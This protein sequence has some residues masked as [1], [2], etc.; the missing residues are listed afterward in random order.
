MKKFRLAEAVVNNF[1]VNWV[2]ILA[3]ACCLC[4]CASAPPMIPIS[5]ADAREALEII[6]STGKRYPAE[7]TRADAEEKTFL[8][9]N[10]LIAHANRK[11]VEYGEL[12]A[13]RCRAPWEYSVSQDSDF[14][15][16][17]YGKK[18]IAV[19]TG[20]LSLVKSDDELAFILAHELGHHIANHLSEQK[21]R[22]YVGELVGG[23][24]SAGVTV[25]VAGA[26]GLE[27][28]PEFED[29]DYL[30]DLVS[31]SFETGAIA[32][33]EVAVMR[34]SR[35][36]EAEADRIAADIISSAGFNLDRAIE[37]YAYLGGVDGNIA[38]FSSFGDSHPT[39]LERLAQ[40]RIFSKWGADSHSFANLRASAEDNNS[41]AQIALGRK[42]VTKG[43][44]EEA[45]YWFNRAAALKDPE[46][47]LILGLLAFDGR[48]VQKDKNMAARWFY[49]AATQGD[50]N[51]QN[52][53]GSQYASGEGVDQDYE[54]SL[55]WYLQSGEQGNLFA[56]RVLGHIFL[57]GRGTD[58]N[59]AEA[60]RW[61]RLAAEKGDSEA[62]FTLSN[63]LRNRLVDEKNRAEAFRWA[64]AAAE[65]GMVAAQFNVAKMYKFGLG[66]RQ[67]FGEAV[68]WATKA[69]N[70]GYDRAQFLL[71]AAYDNGLGVTVDREKAIKLYRLAAEQGHASAQQNLGVLS[72]SGAE[73]NQE[74]ADGLA[75]AS[76]AADKGDPEAQ[77]NL[78]LAYERAQRFALARRWYDSA[79][80][81]G[82]QPALDAR[83]MLYLVEFGFGSK[84]NV[85]VIS[86][87]RLAADSGDANAQYALGLGHHHSVLVKQSDEKAAEWYKL[88]AAQDHTNAQF[89]LAV[90]FDEG[91]L[92]EKDSSKAVYWYRRAAELGHW[93]AQS[94]LG[95][96]LEYGDG[97]E[98]DKIAAY[99]WYLSAA[100]QGDP[101]TQFYVG[102]EYLHGNYLEKD[103]DEGLF[104][105][106]LAAENG[107]SS[108]ATTLGWRYF[109]KDTA[110]FNLNYKEAF[111][112]NKAGA[113]GG[114][115]NAHSNLALHYFTG[116]GVEQ[117]FRRMVEH[118]ILSAEFFT[119]EFRWV[120]EGPDEWLDYKDLA[121]K[122]FM[123]ARGLWWQAVTTGDKKY[124]RRLKALI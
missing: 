122:K 90:L 75:W 30:T 74:T 22:S 86:D 52:M 13:D 82:F 49:L 113:E 80:K 62:Q 83:R 38:T 120:T 35:Q 89:S 101:D 55:S 81:S 119:D 2:L 114:H 28:N 84:S 51:A 112:W 42:S 61:L 108:A 40:L 121:P 24:L 116:Y 1:S 34:Y 95:W 96:S 105:L 43:H 103:L 39:D 16:F 94:S 92:V 6:Q 45:I 107:Q 67:D 3:T 65:S 115:T 93:L 58:Q 54:E 25:L 104:W 11:C 109:T 5:S 98:Q 14:N 63:M 91:V 78:G 97:T 88:A 8:I 44:D 73:T 15:A 31:D 12:S 99:N 66:V 123:D 110:P 79:A 37:L 117:N 85:E 7:I 48:G 9:V 124:I 29:C 20:A 47:Q 18:S 33:R 32:G 111:R 56:Q 71:A 100:R 102:T 46:A 77:Y 26:L 76:L 23:V 59:S 41:K 21:M 50:S 118:L 70:Q 87:L 69:A 27:C 36:Q 68:Y 72:L 64:K 60:A 19:T 17:A 106:S 4:G 10:R 57:E 53:L